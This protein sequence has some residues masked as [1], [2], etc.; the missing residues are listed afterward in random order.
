LGL[1]DDAEHRISCVQGEAGASVFDKFRSVRQKNAGL[2]TLVA[3][4]K[5]LSGGELLEVEKTDVQRF[6]PAERA[7]F[8]FAPVVSVE[9]ERAFSRFNSIFRDNRQSFTIEHLRWYVVAHC[10]A[11]TSE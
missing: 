1:F 11:S 5:T 6:T 2:R 10:N 8:R 4:N 3:L 9:V 7:C